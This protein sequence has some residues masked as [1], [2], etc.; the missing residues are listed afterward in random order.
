MRI[1]IHRKPS[2][3]QND[4]FLSLIE[5]LEGGFAIFAG[6][7]IGLYLNGAARDILIVTALISIVVNA[8]NAATIRY[9]SEHYADE[10]DGREKRSSYHYYFIPAMV[11]FIVYLGISSIAVVPLLLADTLIHGIVAMMV[12][13]LLILFLGGFIRGQRFRHH[14][15]RDGLELSLGGGVIIAV[16]TVAGWI[17][18]SLQL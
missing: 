7:V 15:W 13:C 10:L 5:G 18:S 17:I 14:K 2:A 4:L 9:S 8:V 16:G 3:Y 6:I 11:E 12:I 1:R